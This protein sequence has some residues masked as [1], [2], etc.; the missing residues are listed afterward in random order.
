MFEE[1]LS[2]RKHIYQEMLSSGLFI[3]LG[4]LGFSKMER[5]S[6]IGGRNK[7]L[8]LQQSQ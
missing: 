3:F 8:N 7:G 6:I 5:N 2:N 4:N 1:K